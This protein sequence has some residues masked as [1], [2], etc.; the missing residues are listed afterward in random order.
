MYRYKEEDEDDNWRGAYACR[1]IQKG[2]LLT[3]DFNCHLWDCCADGTNDDVDVP[4]TAACRCGADNC[5]GIRAGFGHLPLEAQQ[6]LRARNPNTGTATASVT[7]P[8]E[9]KALS[10]YVRKKLLETKSQ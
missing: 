3:I 4:V 2:D 6:E 10:P 8:L 7:N 9:G 5:R 1:D